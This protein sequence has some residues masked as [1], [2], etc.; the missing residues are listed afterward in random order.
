[1][2]WKNVLSIVAASALLGVP[3]QSAAH[4]DRDNKQAEHD[5]H[6]KKKAERAAQFEAQLIAR[7]TVLAGSAANATSLVQGLHN[8]TLVTLTRTTTGDVVPCSGRVPLPGCGEATTT[9]VKVE[10]ASPTGPQRLKQVAI[11][12]ALM[13]AKLKELQP[14][15]TVATGEQ[16]R[17]V[18]VGQPSGI[19]TMR[20]KKKSWMQI[21]HSLGLSV[22][23]SQVKAKQGDGKHHDDDDDD[24]DD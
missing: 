8:D 3:L 6:A 12:L 10:F 23:M 7:Y 22:H 20:A 21:V 24:D 5:Q 18:L 19:L 11:A 9:T 2:S 15:I 16:I 13:E 14:G 17:D 4:N 1:M